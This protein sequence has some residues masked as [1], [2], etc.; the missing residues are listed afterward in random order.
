LVEIQMGLYGGFIKALCET[1]D[2]KT[3]S[4]A[5]LARAV[6]S[7]LVDPATVEDATVFI[8]DALAQLHAFTQWT[9]SASALAQLLFD[10]AT[11]SR[12]DVTAIFCFDT[13]AYMQAG[14]KDGTL[15]KRDAG[16]E[17]L[18]DADAAREALYLNDIMPNMSLLFADRA[19]RVWAWK[20]LGEK[21]LE[22]ACRES[23]QC[24]LRF[25]MHGH[26]EGPPKLARCGTVEILHDLSPNCNLGEADFKLVWWRLWAHR[27]IR[28]EPVAVFTV[29]TDLWALL[30][31]HA[32]Q[33][34]AAPTFLKLGTQS[35]CT[36][37][38]VDLFAASLIQ[39]GLWPADFAA[40]LACQSTDYSGRLFDRRATCPWSRFLAHAPNTLRSPPGH[41]ARARAVL[42]RASTVCV[43][44]RNLHNACV[45][46]VNARTAGKRKA[47]DVYQPANVGNGDDFTPSLPLLTPETAHRLARAISIWAVADDRLKHNPPLIIGAQSVSAVVRIPR[48]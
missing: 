15:A 17:M 46:A 4:D 27:H 26:D 6:T 2:G 7:S 25:I 5:M 21:M 3:S 36:A 37:W 10:R 35:K 8:W 22:I 30:I 47:G 45:A 23:K 12:R 13:R 41:V 42:V 14:L 11:R 48:N 9:E 18:P 38:R 1:K 28:L 44:L 32:P 40:L 33:E 34:N 39:D 31:A 19:A 24:H 43:N 20:W 16:G 29:D